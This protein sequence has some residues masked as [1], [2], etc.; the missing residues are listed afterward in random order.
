MKPGTIQGLKMPLQVF[1]HVLEAQDVILLASDFISGVVGL[2]SEDGR[3]STSENTVDIVDE[4]QD[5]QSQDCPPL[6]KQPTIDTVHHHTL[7]GQ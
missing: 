6:A 1:R 2:G 4:V 7:D 5:K 3:E